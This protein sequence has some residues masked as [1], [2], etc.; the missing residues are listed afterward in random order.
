MTIARVLLLLLWASAACAKVDTLRIATYNLLKFPFDN[1]ASRI[2]HF[3][4]VMQALQPDIL[5]VQELESEQGM[6]TF[7][8]EV[9]NAGQGNVYQS[10]PYANGFDTDNGLFYKTGKVSL[11]GA[12]QIRT[13]L[14]DI[15]EYVL[16]APGAEF[17]CYSL[18]L[19]AGNTPEDENRRRNE[20]TILRNYLNNLPA[21]TN[22]IVVGDFNSYRSSDAGLAKLTESQADNDGRGFDPLN[23]TGS[24]NNNSGFA[25]IHT[26][27]TRTAAVDSGSTGGLDDR[28]DLLLVSSGVI[29]PGGMDI[30]NG[31]YRSFGNDGRHF[32]QDIN[33]GT[34]TAVSQNVANALHFASDHLP[35]FADFVVGVT[36]RVEEKSENLPARFELLQNYPNPFNAKTQISFVLPEPARVILEVYNL[37]GSRLR[38]LDEA[39]YPAGTHRVVWDGL[40]D[41]GMPAAS[42]V[43][44]YILKAA[45]FSVMRKMVLL[46]RD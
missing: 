26:Q 33:A 43:Y 28:F 36:S 3:R 15:S 30:L 9:L 46:P 12:Q 42:G 22:F 8:R 34:N 40:N 31:T 4:T 13:S 44:L 20:A 1:G 29:A 17:H 24:W 16:S 6:L 23:S 11:L 5:L 45:S 25:V 39:D 35:V 14:R 37:Q 18:H 2:I 7:L 38:N 32:N 10:A 27:S 19:K 41:S 21:N